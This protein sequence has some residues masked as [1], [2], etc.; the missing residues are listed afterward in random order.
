MDTKPEPTSDDEPL[1]SNAVHTP[2]M[3]QKIA[4]FM[5]EVGREKN[6]EEK[7]NSKTEKST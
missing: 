4:K 3:W 6:A 1:F 5:H 7:P 2:E